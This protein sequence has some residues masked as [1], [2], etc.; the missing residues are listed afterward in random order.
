[1]S[2]FTEVVDYHPNRAIGHRKSGAFTH[3]WFEDGAKLRVRTRLLR[4]LLNH[5]WQHVERLGYPHEDI[6]TRENQRYRIGGLDVA[7]R[8]FY[9]PQW[10]ASS[11]L[12]KITCALASGV[13]TESPLLELDFPDG[14]K[15]V[16]TKHV[17]A[18]QLSKKMV[19]GGGPGYLGALKVHPDALQ[20]YKKAA[21][22]L[23][24]LH[25]NGLVHGH[26]HGANWL[27]DKH[28]GLILVDPKLWSEIP[29]E[30]PTAIKRHAAVVHSISRADPEAGSH[31]L[32]RDL[33]YLV[34]SADALGLNVKTV[35]DEYV[36]AYER[37]YSK[38]FR[39]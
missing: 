8:T 28:G 18:E 25:V 12:R 4:A 1:M 33:H 2:S 29:I 39:N 30:T 3:Y 24:K 36:S 20:H 13:L 6:F 35:L 19:L 26:P 9:S 5:S 16:I 22:V 15:R 23:A 31:A 32:R 38:R 10:E 14:R 7:A 21:G 37:S 11:R 17:E 34:Q 27:V